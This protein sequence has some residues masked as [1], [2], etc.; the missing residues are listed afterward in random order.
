MRVETISCL[1]KSLEIISMDVRTCIQRVVYRHVVVSQ[2]QIVLWIL[3]SLGNLTSWST[4]TGFA[5]E[6]NQGSNYVIRVR[7]AQNGLPVDAVRAIAQ[8]PDGYLWVATFGGLARFDGNR[9]EIFQT[10]NTPELS[11]NL[12]NALFCDRQG[13]LWIGH[14]SGQITVMEG[15]KFR[16]LQ[17]RE[18]WLRIPIRGFGDDA[19]GEVWVL[20]ALWKLAVIGA[21]DE[22]NSVQPP[23]PSDP[24]LYLSSSA[25][26]GQLRVITQRGQCYVVDR[27]GAYRDTN[28]PSFGLDG[29]RVIASAKEGYWGV[30]DTRLRRWVGAE[31]VEDMGEINW[32]EAIFATTCEWREVVVAGSFREGLSMAGRDGMRRHFDVS[33]GLPSNWI[34]VLFVDAGGTL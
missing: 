32:G 21:K 8:T 16:R 29:R 3:L 20:N 24:A 7:N 13:R 23:D 34:A 10:A 18:D 6:T 31:M 30:R 2:S 11:D 33:S 14:D 9:F 22:M 15:R 4:A 12:I 19:K 17:M 1:G 26:D 28:A 5:A 25:L 27:A